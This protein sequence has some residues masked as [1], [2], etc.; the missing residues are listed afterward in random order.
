MRRQPRANSIFHGIWFSVMVASILELV[1]ASN[2][3]VQCER[4]LSQYELAL[5]APVQLGRLDVAHELLWQMA[6][7]PTLE[8]WRC[9][10]FG[11][12]WPLRMDDR[13]GHIVA[14]VLALR[15]LPSRTCQLDMEPKGKIISLD[16]LKTST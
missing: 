9:M 8:R 5:E 10:V 13:R 1:E 16:L 14:L 2:V 3:V 6:H 12:T 7:E 4:V 11:C 15:D